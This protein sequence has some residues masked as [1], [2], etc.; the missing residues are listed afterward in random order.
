MYDMSVTVA[1]SPQAE[2]SASAKIAR[3]ADMVSRRLQLQERIG[4][5]I[6]DIVQK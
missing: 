5:D 2:S 6:A 1:T 3:I 4:A